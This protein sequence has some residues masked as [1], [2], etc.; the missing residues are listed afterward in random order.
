[1]KNLFQLLG[2]ISLLC[3]SFIYTEKTVTVVKEFDD[4]MIE[5]KNKNEVDKVNAVEA[6]I[7]GN[8]II[9]GIAGL[10][11]DIDKS[12]SKMKR[13][14]KYNDKLLEYN[15]VIP[16]V[17]LQ[18]NLNKYV[19][20]GNTSKNMVSLLFL[21]D[22]NDSVQK[23]LDVLKNKQVKATF[24]VDG[25]WVEKNNDYLIKIINAGHDIGNLSYNYDYS[26]SS[27]AWLDNK[28]KNV[29][30][31]TYGYCYMKEDNE[32]SLSICSNNKNY[33]IRPTVII[34]NTP[35][36]TVKENLK[37]GSLIALP[38]SEE[39]EKELGVI[40]SFIESKGL[41]IESLSNHL[42]EF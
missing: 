18:S 9:P 5:I 38:I 3:V 40:I 41:K 12:Y 4:I 21:V 19:V 30:K 39:V 34:D 17:S 14:G 28:I 7:E 25:N 11:V 32:T 2:I 37:A 16:N 29:S 20:S 15:P 22:S 26:N 27:F 42:S 35:T 10:E 1:M 24:F 36:I 8:I 6:V 13:Y 31:Q 23:T 33:T